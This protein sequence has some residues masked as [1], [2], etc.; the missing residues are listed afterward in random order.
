M[1]GIGIGKRNGQGILI[2]S[3]GKWKGDKYVGEFKDGVFHGKGTYTWSEG[4]FVGKW[5]D[6]KRKN[7]IEYNKYGDI[8]HKVVNGERIEQ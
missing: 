4:K 1:L 3:E 7:G 2:I 8:T 6:G 5:K